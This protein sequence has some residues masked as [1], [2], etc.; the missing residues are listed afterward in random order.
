MRGTISDWRIVSPSL[1]RPRRI[2]C[3]GSIGAGGD[4]ARLAD[5]SGFGDDELDLKPPE[6]APIGTIE[7]I[8]I[9]ARELTGSEGISDVEI[10]ERLTFERSVNTYPRLAREI[11]RLD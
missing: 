7:R 4:N 5:L 2:S 6:A 9:A 8:A 11:R 10:I 1:N 3:E